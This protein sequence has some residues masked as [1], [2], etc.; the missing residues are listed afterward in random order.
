VRGVLV[1][2]VKGAWPSSFVHAVGVGVR[3]SGP[4][5]GRLLAKR[6]GGAVGAR[7]RVGGSGLVTGGACA[8]EVTLRTRSVPQRAPR[9]GRTRVERRAMRVNRS[10]VGTVVWDAAAFMAL[11][12]LPP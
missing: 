6:L 9:G 8:F 11:R 10:A 7:L 5:V 1:D 4:R 2:A 3:G 12:E